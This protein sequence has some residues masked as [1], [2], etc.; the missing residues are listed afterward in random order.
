MSE[1]SVF[2]YDFEKP[3][4]MPNRDECL[5]YHA[6][7]YADGETVQGDWTIPSLHSYLGKY[8]VKGK[9]VLDIGTASGFIAFGAEK[10]GAAEV[11][12]LD[13]AS[14]YEF[15]GVPFAGSTE[16][17]DA[18]LWRQRLYDENLLKLRKSWWYGWH[19]N[20]SSARCIYMP[21]ASLHDWDERFDVVIAGAIVLHLSDPVYA[22]GTWAKVAKE[23]VILPFTEVIWDDD[24]Y[25]R[26]I[27]GW[28]DPEVIYSWWMLS[29]G[30]YRKI[31]DNLGFDITFKTTYAFYDQGGGIKEK[32]PTIIAHRR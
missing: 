4:T 8:D 3:W 27:T 16:H 24:M 7:K 13:I 23:A 5:F 10:A 1:Q 6:M 22:I 11:T 14:P 2:Q 19:K 32:R 28:N 9:T 25:M 17:Q 18:A 15:R 12:G 26:P 29:V 21:H 30:L 20:K 31:F